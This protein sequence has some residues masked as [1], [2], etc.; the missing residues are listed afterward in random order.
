[1]VGKSGASAKPVVISSYGTGAKPIITGFVTASSWASVSNGVYQVYIPGAKST[2]NMVTMNN[3]PQALGRYP[4]TDTTNGGYLNYETSSGYTSITDNELTTSTNWVGAEVVVRKKLWVLDRCKITAHSGGT[5][6][7]TNTNG[8][9][10]T[11]TNGYGYFIQNDA[12][13]LDKPGEWY[14]KSSTKY[15]QM[16]FGS[17]LP[18][19]YTVKVSCIDTLLIMSS[20]SYINISNLVF[21]G[22]ATSRPNY[23]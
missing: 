5:L 6:T 4:N 19:S 2:L 14:Y 8:S 21:E 7:F 13:T 20:K 23:S 18:A 22:T 9:T 11:A 17:A 16:Y 1:M 3:V 10:Y 12:R 15:L